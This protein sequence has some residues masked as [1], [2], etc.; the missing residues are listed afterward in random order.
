MTGYTTR[1]TIVCPEAMIADANQLGLVL[2]ER[3]TD[4]ETF[5]AARYQDAGGNRYLGS[6]LKCATDTPST[7]RR[8]SGPMP[9]AEST[10]VGKTIPRIVF[11]PSSP[12]RT[13]PPWRIFS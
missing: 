3:A 10:F 9:M 13:M 6:R 11:L 8:S 7:R 1:A 5:G 12:S 4:D 2:G